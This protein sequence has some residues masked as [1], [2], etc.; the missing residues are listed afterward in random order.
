MTLG[1]PVVIVKAIYRAQD[2]LRAT[3]ALSAVELSTVY[4]LSKQ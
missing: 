4:T 1:G 2:H 3:N